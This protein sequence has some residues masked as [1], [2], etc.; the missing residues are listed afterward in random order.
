MMEPL[1]RVRQ[2]RHLANPSAAGM[3]RL[4]HLLGRYLLSLRDMERTME[5]AWAF[6][7]A[8]NPM[9]AAPGFLL[10]AS[11]FVLTWLGAKG[12]LVQSAP[13]P[14]AL[15]IRPPRARLSSR[16]WPFLP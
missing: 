14:P 9:R 13:P 16:P 7:C 6:Y 15:P 8:G 10:Y 5:R 3:R 4:G 12:D 2:S 1:K 11:P